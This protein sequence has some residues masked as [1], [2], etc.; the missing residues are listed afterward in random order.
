MRIDVD[1][2]LLEREAE[3]NAPQKSPRKSDSKPPKKRKVAPDE[4]ENISPAPPKAK[5]AK[6]KIELTLPPPLPAGPSKITSIKLKLGPKPKEP[7]SF[8]CCLCISQDTDGLLTVH[9][10]PRDHAAGPSDRYGRWRAHPECA[11]VVPET[12]VDDVVHPDGSKER[13]VFGV[14]VIVKDRWNLVRHHK[15]PTANAELIFFF[16]IEMH[17]VRE[18]QTQSSRGTHPMHQ[19]EMSEGVP[20]LVRE[21]RPV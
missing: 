6:V 3:R 18:E 5:K 14:D 11:S 9:D 12:W 2:L 16:I 7:D 1:Q 20:C 15:L 17:R 21:G 10:P 13:M 8:P 19:R 4:L